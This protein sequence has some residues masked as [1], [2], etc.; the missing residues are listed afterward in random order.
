[1]KKIETREIETINYNQYDELLDC[2]GPIIVAGLKMYP[3]EIL[4]K[5]RKTTLKEYK[6]LKQELKSIGY[7]L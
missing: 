5:C 1:M 7:K 6:E 2:E 4:K 3:S